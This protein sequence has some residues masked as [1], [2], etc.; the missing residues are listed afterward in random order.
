M[1][2]NIKYGDKELNYKDF[3]TNLSSNVDSYVNSHPEW[4]DT[5]KNLFKDY[6]SKLKTAMQDSLNNDT[7][8]FSIDEFGTITDKYG[9]FKN[10]SDN[11]NLMDKN[12][13]LVTDT[14]N[15]TDKQKAKLTAFKVPQIIANYVHTIANATIQ[16]MG[17]QKKSIPTFADYWQQQ[18]DPEHSL[19]DQNFWSTLDTEGSYKNRIA[20]TLEDI[21]K[22]TNDYNLSEDQLQN[23]NKYRDLLNSPTVGSDQWKKDLRMQAARMGWG[24]W[25]DQFFGFKSST[26]QP[27]QNNNVN[28]ND[29][30]WLLNTYGTDADKQ[31]YQLYP[32]A[33]A[34]IIANLKKQYEQG[35][36]AIYDQAKA[37][38]E[39]EKKAIADKK[40]QDYIAKNPW[41]YDATKRQFT[42]D[43]VFGNGVTNAR[44]ETAL[45][46]NSDLYKALNQLSDWLKTL[47]THSDL[48]TKNIVTL[49]N[50][51]GQTFSLKNYGD[52]LAYAK[53]LLDKMDKEQHTHWWANNFDRVYDKK[54][55]EVFRV[56]NSKTPSGEYLYLM[57]RNGKLYTYYS[58]PYSELYKDTIKKAQLGVKLITKEQKEKQAYEKTLPARAK[59]NNRNSTQ[60]RNADNTEFTGSDLTR[61]LGIAADLGSIGASYIPGYGTAASAVLGYGSTLANLG[62]DIA[63]GTDSAGTI[64][65]NTVKSLGMD[66]LGLIPG[67]GTSS[68][69]AKIGTTLVKYTPRILAT[70]GTMSTVENMPQ[71]ISSFKKVLTPGTKLTVQ[72]YQ[73]MAE[74]IKL[75][76]MGHNAPKRKVTR[77]NN[78][79]VGTRVGVK[80]R[81][82]QTGEVKTFVFKGD[83]AK[84][85]RNTK[86]N[87]GIQGIID[88]HPELKGYQLEQ[89]NKVSLFPHLRSFRDENKKLRSPITYNS[90]KTQL[91]DVYTN[92]RGQSLYSNKEGLRGWLQPYGNTTEHIKVGN[93]VKPT[94]TQPTSKPINTA[95][96]AKAAETRFINKQMKAAKAEAQTNL[97]PN[98][99]YQQLR[100]QINR[101]RR[102]MQSDLA[103]GRTVSA[104]A[105]RQSINQDMANLRAMTPEYNRLRGMLTSSPTGRQITFD[106]KG[107]QVVRNW[108][109]VVK[110]YGLRYKKGGVIKAQIGTKTDWKLGIPEF[111][112][113]DYKPQLDTSKLYSF[114]NGKIGD[115]LV[116]NQ[117]GL[118]VGRY[119]PTSGYTREQ[120]QAIQ[121]QQQYKDF[122][123]KLLDQNGVFTPVGEAW[124]KA[125][126]ANLPTDSKARFFNAN[127]TLRT[128]WTSNNNDPYG[129]KPQTFT[130]LRDY[131]HYMRNDD[132]AGARHNIFINKGKR[133]YYKNNNGQRVY[134]NPNDI[135]K[136][137]LADTTTT[138]FNPNTLTE[139]TDQEILGLAASPTT[140][141]DNGNPMQQQSE[142]K[143]FNLNN[144]SPT[145]L[146][147]IP[148][149]VAAD[150]IN[151]KISDL[152]MMNP[153]LLQP[154]A[155][156]RNVYSDYNAETTGY[157]NWAYLR[158]L[159]S[160]PITS[161]ASLNAAMRLDAN[162]RGAQG[163]QQAMQQSDQV[164]RQSAEAAWQ[165][166]KENAQ[167]SWQTANANREAIYRNDEQNLKNKLA[168][169]TQ[170][171][172][173]WDT[174]A[175]EIQ[176]DALSNYRLR[177]A[178]ADQFAQKD[179]EQYTRSQITNP[180]VYTR[181]G[182][183]QNDIDVWN[184]VNNG[185]RQPSSLSQ[186]ERQ[187]YQR[188]T[189]A[190]NQLQNDSMR[191][192]YNIPQSRYY[193]PYKATYTPS[194]ALSKNGGKLNIAFLKAA[195]KDADRF[196]KITKDFADRTERAIA[197]LQSTRKKKKTK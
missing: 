176:Q 133:Y 84:T 194:I 125:V 138:E 121:N 85:I 155:L 131:V 147:G 52:L 165:Q 197:R 59:A 114:I 28:P 144:I 182:L 48:L 45:P 78:T 75:V 159:A 127:G 4:S 35:E 38:E 139:W 135:A 40:W 98:S 9:E 61:L 105:Y 100:E 120:V 86:D 3:I 117:K 26:E 39:Q 122:E 179:I 150:R 102:I 145:L 83:D 70:L 123:S 69:A 20:Q 19:D 10:A 23:I 32:N 89:V 109:D 156:H 81:N 97:A 170:K 189:Q 47:K 77:Y 126:D 130:N 73:N 146:Y 101:Q 174:L 33:R 68:K 111:N 43:K 124:A 128:K 54:G 157:N 92:D 27:T 142:Q 8:R 178:R 76:A 2:K 31:N 71:I 91:Y 163:Y 93:Q 173:I 149:A 196:Y 65:W 169:Y 94:T 80:M 24:N 162:S 96:R 62:A 60:Q 192:Y 108:Q 25:N 107:T 55:N 57:F 188:V 103:A 90:K 110:K 166:E 168:Y 7:D 41:I 42:N 64:A 106:N 18:H 184:S 171:Y 153:M 193:T 129:R 118:G 79:S 99:P 11:E 187:A 49:Q 6:Y 160:Q 21:T 46:Q 148:R 16:K 191:A 141:S 116:S 143:K 50:Q 53:P 154:M 56:K 95:S 22:Y 140:I 12:G 87:T 5:Q 63:D 183:S 66:T 30:Q 190:A 17:E 152:S 14:S 82:N 58:K 1:A 37:V 167:N 104:N 44:K 185:I 181:Y 136:Y 137:R 177:Q 72:D 175:Q 186:E 119:I 29:D 74:G 88:K 195:A 172:Q 34:T 67:F 13:N 164:A 115:A 51:N 158:N 134:V 15:L 180:Q 113:N 36:Q 161:D 151:K 132:I 112:V